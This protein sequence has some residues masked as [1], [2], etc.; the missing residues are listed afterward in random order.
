MTEIERTLIRQL[1]GDKKQL[2]CFSV[3]YG[4][5]T[6]RYSPRNQFL[7]EE[8]PLGEL[9]SCLCALSCTC[10]SRLT[11]RL[12]LMSAMQT[13]RIR[14]RHIYKSW[15]MLRRTSEVVPLEKHC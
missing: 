13:D 1:C 11:T 3:N 12:G 4:P 14:L 7:S 6:M 8:A 2:I 5:I 15:K 9:G 10:H